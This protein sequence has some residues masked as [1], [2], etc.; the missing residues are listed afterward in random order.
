MIRLDAR[1]F[2]ARF[3]ETPVP[4]CK[5]LLASQCH[6]TA[7]DLCIER[8]VL[9]W[10]ACSAGQPELDMLKEFYLDKFYVVTSGTTVAIRAI[11]LMRML[12]FQSFDIFGLDSCLMD[13][14][15]HAYEQK[16]NDKYAKLPVWVRPQGRDDLAQR[17]ICS[18]WMMKQSQDWMDLI[19]DKGDT[20]RVNV[21]GDGL[22]ATIMRIAAK[23]GSVVMTEVV[24]EKVTTES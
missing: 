21:R 2:N 15:H 18:P 19:R 13:G 16:E 23:L 12:G 9:I 11:S 10:H 7:F 14:A 4:G 24:E 3:L 17:F 8:E 1:E 22:I 5:Y 6:A 20:F